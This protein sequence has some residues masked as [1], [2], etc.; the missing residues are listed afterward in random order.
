MALTSA[1]L[2]LLIKQ[3]ENQG[4]SLQ[5]SSNGNQYMVKYCSDSQF[6]RTDSGGLVAI[7]AIDGYSFVDYSSDHQD[8]D[9]SVTTAYDD[10][11]LLGGFVNQPHYRTD[12]SDSEKHRQDLATAI[13]GNTK[14]RKSFREK[15]D[16]QAKNQSSAVVTLP[17]I[18]LDSSQRE[19]VKSLIQNGSDG[20]ELSAKFGR[21]DQADLKEICDEIGLDPL[22]RI[23]KF[24][25]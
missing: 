12:F 15:R 14:D 16:S 13:S 11:T 19:Q 22:D 10:Q 5:V 7:N 1:K 20:R 3:S 25:A 2:D 24:L 21:I 8:S 6:V 23:L 18:T 4:K 9:D 17:A